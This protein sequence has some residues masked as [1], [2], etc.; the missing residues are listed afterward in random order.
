MC[1]FDESSMKRERSQHWKRIKDLMETFADPCDEPIY[2]YTS[3]SAFQGIVESGEI[4][5]TNTDFVNDTTECQALRKETG[6]F[7]EG[8]LSFNRYTKKWWP[9]FLEYNNKDASSN[10]I[11]SFSTKSDSLE[12]LRAYGNICIGFNAE[13]LEKDGFYL[14]KCIYNKSEIKEWILDKARAKEWTLSDPDRTR[15]SIGKDNVTTTSYE[16]GRGAAA[17]SLFFSAAIKL[18]HLCYKNEEEVRLLAYS[19]HDWKYPN[20]PSMYAGDR[21]IHF[22]LHPAIEIP[23]PYVK[24]FVSTQPEG[25]YDFNEEYKGKTELQV[26]E[27]KREKEKNQKRALLPIKEIW[28]GPTPHK[29]ETRL[30]CEILLKEKGYKDVPVKLLQIPY[31]GF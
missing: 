31:R 17:L 10:Y 21:P 11:A 18:K 15:Q 25:E 7:E 12:Q 2:H 6:L 4:W 29:E 27:G 26:K 24:Y 9:S 3:A 16:D 1:K 19:S 13:R 14:H 22:R 5:L 30:A 23:V 28:I 8:E 20:S